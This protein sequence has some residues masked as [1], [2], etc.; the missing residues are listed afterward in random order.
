MHITVSMLLTQFLTEHPS[1]ALLGIM[2]DTEIS[3]IRLLPADAS[4]CQSDLLYLTD[5]PERP[6]SEECQNLQIVCFSSHATEQISGTSIYTTENLSECLNCM[7]EYFQHFAIWQRKMEFAVLQA[8]NL[9]IL[10]D[11]CEDIIPSP[12]LV[13]DPALKLLAHSENYSNFD[14]KIFQKAV[15]NGY[16]DAE[17]VRYF[18]SS[19]AFENVNTY[20]AAIGQAD[21][22]RMH[23]DIV[24]SVNV[25][26]HLVVY[27]ILIDTQSMPSS[28]IR[29]LFD[30]FCDFVRRY[31]ENQHISFE[32]NR[33]ATDYFL[34]DLLEHPETSEET[35]R[36]R[37]RLYDLDFS[38]SYLLMDLHSD[39]RIRSNEN[40]YIQLL[41]NNLINCRIF[42]W[43]E[44]IILLYQLPISEHYHYKEHI[45]RIM[46]PLLKEI[47]SSRPRLF[48]SRFFSKISLFA[49]AY[50]QAE[51][52]ALLP[53]EDT[54]DPYFFYDENSLSDL[55]IQKD[56]EEILFDYCE[57]AVLDLLH[58]KTKKSQQSL[59]ILYAYL[60]NDR[61]MTDAANL[62]H[63]HRNNVIYHIRQLSETYGLDFDDPDLR[64]R[65]MLSFHAIR[66]IRSR[67]PEPEQ[68]AD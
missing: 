32:K 2:S 49:L 37:I 65:L 52:T 68:T 13:Y 5:R 34:M 63:M 58:Q 11:L 60:R 40:Y 47:S 50:R 24:Q 36:D 45:R 41:R 46:D 61:K 17:S 14:D 48:I 8:D 55:F 1:A 33:S 4:S 39:L 64:E 26:N 67:F 53:Q 51:Y 15:H 20:G 42:S 21:E 16:L 29:Q 19:N 25:D 28:Y 56:K 6:L 7:L 38:G 9:Q 12:M 3:G 44:S 66:Y 35:I 27:C 10:T 57:P 22:Y 43:K 54:S 59:R 31:L 30:I 23:N 18:E 62:L